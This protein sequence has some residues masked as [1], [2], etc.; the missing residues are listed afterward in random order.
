MSIQDDIYGHILVC[1]KCS[2]FFTKEGIS[3]FFCDKKLSDNRY[4]CRL[5]EPYE[6]WVAVYMCLDCVKDYILDI[7]ES[8]LS[9]ENFKSAIDDFKRKVGRL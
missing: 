4:I 7:R 6:G 5:C 8:R 1:P 9:I 2:V 3:C